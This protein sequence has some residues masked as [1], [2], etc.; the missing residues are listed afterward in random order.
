MSGKND[1]IYYRD[2]LRE[3]I[4]DANENSI[5]M[6][7]SVKPRTNEIIITFKSGEYD[8]TSVALVGTK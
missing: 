1:P 4:K 3:L 5:N 8:C 2:K 6:G 7:A